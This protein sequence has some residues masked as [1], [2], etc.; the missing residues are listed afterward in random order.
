MAR[1]PK[2]W[3]QRPEAG[4]LGKE[5]TRRSGGRCELCGGRNEVRVY[6]LPPFP[7]EPEAERALLGCAVCRDA[8]EGGALDPIEARFLEKAV[9]DDRTAVKLAAARLLIALDG[10][11]HPWT[12][13]ALEAIDVDPAT[14][15]FREPEPEVEEPRRRR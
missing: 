2:R 8:L 14:G 6:E 3:R 11:N 15:E 13:E 9:W 12:R 4:S 7:P 5:L 10:A 1:A